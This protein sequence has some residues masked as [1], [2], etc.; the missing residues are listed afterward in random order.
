MLSVKWSACSIKDDIASPMVIKGLSLMPNTIK[1]IITALKR[2]AQVTKT[3]RPRLICR[4]QDCGTLS[5]RQYLTVAP[6]DCEL[7][8]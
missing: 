1:N 7:F 2:L 5:E 3:A 8:V 4:S 6:S